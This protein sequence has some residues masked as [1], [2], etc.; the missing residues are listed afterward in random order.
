MFTWNDVIYNTN[1][2]NTVVDTFRIDGKNFAVSKLDDYTVQVVTPEVFPP[3]ELGFGGMTIIPRHILQ[4]AVDGKRF[5]AV[6]GIDTPPSQLVGS[7]PF[8]LKEYK[9]GRCPGGAQPVFLGGG[10]ERPAAAV[11][12]QCAV[13]G[14][15]GP[16]TPFPC[17]S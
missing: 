5:E 13:F 15:A 14:G 12:R 1:I 17:D 3:F 11:S 16:K 7:G 9:P 8:R 2:V 6:Y 4:A 10:Q